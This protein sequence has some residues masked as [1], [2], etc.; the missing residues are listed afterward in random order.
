MRLSMRLA[1]GVVTTC[2]GLSVNAQLYKAVLLHP[3]NGFNVSSANDVSASSQVGMGSN[4]M[5]AGPL[6]THALVW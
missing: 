1:V 6:D 5:A 2:T 3:L 4:N